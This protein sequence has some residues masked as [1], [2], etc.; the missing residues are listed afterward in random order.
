[1]NVPAVSVFEYHP[2]TVARVEGEH[3]ILHIKPMKK[4]KCWTRKLYAAIEN[5]TVTNNSSIFVEGN[6]GETFDVD[7][8]SHLVYVGAGVGFAGLSASLLNVIKRYENN[9]LPNLKSIDVFLTVIDDEHLYWY[10]KELEI[11]KKCKL[12]HLHTNITFSKFP[13][14]KQN[15]YNNQPEGEYTLSTD[16]ENPLTI[17]FSVGRVNVSEAFKSFD[18]N[19]RYVFFICSPLPL[20]DDLSAYVYTHLKKSGI[21]ADPFDM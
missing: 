2:F 12:V 17:P 7:N 8:E 14:K 21:Y 15:T 5:K 9:E 20:Y 10:K 19:E 18:G 16:P 6:Y 3:V 11:L 13:E 4:P 1:M